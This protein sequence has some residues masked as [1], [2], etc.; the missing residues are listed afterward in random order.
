MSKAAKNLG[1]VCVIVL[2][3]LLIVGQAK[4]D[5]QEAVMLSRHTP[6]GE[7]RFVEMND[8]IETSSRGGF[9]GEEGVTR[10][11]SRLRTVKREFDKGASDGASRVT[12]TFDR[13]A[14]FTET[15]QAPAQ[16]DSDVDDPTDD[17]NPLAAALGPMLGQSL[18]FTLN[19]KGRVV[20]SKGVD[21]LYA[22]VEESA[23]GG[24][25]FVQLEEELADARLRF[26]WDDSHACLYPNKKVKVGDTW[27]A[28]SVQPSL[29]QKDILRTYQ[30]KVEFIG[31]REGRP[32]VDIAYD[33]KLKEMDDN[34]GKARM[35]GISM[36]L[37]DGQASGKATYDVKDGEFVTQTEELTMNLAGTTDGTKPGDKED[38]AANIKTVHTM[39]VVSEAARAAQRKPKN[40]D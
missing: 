4:G 3:A 31:E 36:S 34:K 40:S 38:V 9:Y 22:A 11:S 33:V 37:K 39:T 13:V 35:F 26:Y 8:D 7:V 18:Q 14:M 27:E 6:A 21:E 2:T 19:D 12:L 23:A 25:I 5:E 1:A 15:A 17:I 20:E 28:T 16:F 24:M 30:C 29:Y 10:K 32:V